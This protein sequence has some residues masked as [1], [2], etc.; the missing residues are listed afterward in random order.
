MLQHLQLM[1]FLLMQKGIQ[2]IVLAMQLQ[3]MCKYS[4]KHLLALKLLRYKAKLLKSQVKL[5]KQQLPMQKAIQT[6]ALVLQEIMKAEKISK[7]LGHSLTETNF[8]V[9]KASHWI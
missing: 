9:E 3:Q 6:T 7:I 2:T 1:T 8:S 4:D 5:H